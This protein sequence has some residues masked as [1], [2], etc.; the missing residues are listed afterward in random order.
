MRDTPPEVE[1]RF[2]DMML[3]RS[4]EERLK[5]GCS[6]RQFAQTVVRASVLAK[7]PR[8][9]AAELRRELFRQF[10]GRDVSPAQ[11]RKVLSELEIGDDPPR[12]ST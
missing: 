11:C 6:M 7:H 12:E 1:K 2:R 3:Q 9:T 5:M 4:G 10:Y 8:A